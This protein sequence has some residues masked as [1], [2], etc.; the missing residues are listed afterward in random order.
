MCVNAGPR[1]EFHQHV[2]AY[3]AM[4]RT[5]ATDNECNIRGPVVSSGCNRL[6]NQDVIDLYNRVPIGAG[7]TVC[8]P[9]VNWFSRRYAMMIA[10]LIYR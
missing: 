7:A 3:I 5:I 10:C 1:C 6:F 9:S 8:G 2:A 4:L